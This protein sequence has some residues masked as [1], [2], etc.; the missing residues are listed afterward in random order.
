MKFKKLLSFVFSALIL[1]ST[2][3]GCNILPFNSINQTDSSA[4]GNSKDVLN[5]FN[6]SEYLPES[7]IK[8][9]ENK[10]NIKVNY[11]TYSSNEEMLARIMAGDD[12]FDISVASDYMVDV[13]RKQ[14][15]MEEIDT[16]NVP[17]LKNIGD[18]FKNLAFDPGN[19]YSV[20]YMWGTAV[21]AVNTKKVSGNITSYSDLWDSKFKGSLVVLDDQRALIGIALKK[22]GYSLNESDPAKLDQ[23]KT[24]LLKLK[25]NIKTFNSD[26]P[27]TE[28]IN[29]TAAAG[30][31]WG[32]EAALAAK[33]NKDIKTFFPKE[34]MYLWQD[35]F[36]IPKGALH[37]KNAET[38]IN[39]ILDP[40][41]SANISK[42]F[43][44]ANPN[45][46]AH[47][48]IDK[49]TLSNI[50]I[51]PT[52]N[53]LKIAERIKDLGDTTKLYDKIWAEVKG[54]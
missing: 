36:V 48:F 21:I 45:T 19:K 10:Y 5:V 16:N 17:N 46:T 41:V 2:I 49:S 25:A 50:T 40:N 43:P 23:A 38:F 14:K 42:E 24:E 54:K 7:V 1:G 8:D 51:Y 4:S 52:D 39:F 18:Q 53:E 26:S 28:L 30:Y 29:G 22:L 35:N 13:M 27:K 44:Y 3:T 12:I 37:K 11:M 15:L 47:Q 33:E 31:L 34:G 6:W 9:F 32:A 20:P